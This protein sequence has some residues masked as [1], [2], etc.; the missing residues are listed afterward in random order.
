MEGR[1]GTDKKEMRK[2]RASSVPHG[3]GSTRGKPNDNKQGGEEVGR[4]QTDTPSVARGH[5]HSDHGVRLHV[6]TLRNENREKKNKKKERSNEQSNSWCDMSKQVK[7]QRQRT[8]LFSVFY[9]N[10]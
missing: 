1:Q 6:K 5:T 4:R 10:F 3:V 7:Q 2:K 9:F 8:G